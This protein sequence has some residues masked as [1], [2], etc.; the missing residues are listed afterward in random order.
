MSTGDQFLILGG[1]AAGVV[2]SGA[3]ARLP[4]QDRGACASA[5]PRLDPKPGYIPWRPPAG[6]G[7]LPP[8]P[9]AG[10]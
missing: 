1:S 9:R 8:L 6:G 3:F 7:I 2:Y 10:V 5:A 4:P